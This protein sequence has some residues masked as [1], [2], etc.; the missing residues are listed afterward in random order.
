MLTGSF[1]PAFT[2]VADEA[3]AQQQAPPAVAGVLVT[4]PGRPESPC[5]G[6]AV[7]ADLPSQQDDD[8]GL[9]SVNFG[10]QHPDMGLPLSLLAK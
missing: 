4:S 1:A 9:I 2:T 5:C 8:T 10:G 6:A 3:P 7:V